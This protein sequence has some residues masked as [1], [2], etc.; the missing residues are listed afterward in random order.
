MI[1]DI[2]MFFDLFKAYVWKNDIYV[3][4]EPHLP[5]HRITSTGEE[6][7]IYNGITDWVYEGKD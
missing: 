7:V 1:T 3:K 5:S 6:N 2:N 4:V